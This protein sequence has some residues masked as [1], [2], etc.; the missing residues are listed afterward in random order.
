LKLA[1]FPFSDA[2]FRWSWKLHGL[3]TF[4]LWESFVTALQVVV[5]CVRTK[6]EK[7]ADQEQFN[8]WHWKTKCTCL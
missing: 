2:I 4:K 5:W 3:V 6:N 8:T 1:G 7:N